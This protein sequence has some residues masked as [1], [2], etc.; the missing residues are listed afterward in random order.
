[1]SGGSSYLDI[2]LKNKEKKI[3]SSIYWL[4]S[5]LS[6]VIYDSNDN[7][8]F[9]ITTFDWYLL[10]CILISA[11]F[12]LMI[13]FECWFLWRLCP[14]VALFFF[15]FGFLFYVLMNY[16]LQLSSRIWF[17]QWAL[18]QM[19]YLCSFPC[20]SKVEGKVGDFRPSSCL[21]TLLIY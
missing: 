17:W 2:P 11:P 5:W 15:F 20:K 1:M 8:K 10:I 9:K 6:F 14:T 16:C 7:S 3:I 4:K 18:D 19:E 13:F 21:C 12:F